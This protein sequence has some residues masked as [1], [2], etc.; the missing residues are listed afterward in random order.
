MFCLFLLQFVSEDR[1]EDKRSNEQVENSWRRRTWPD[2]LFPFAQLCPLGI[3]CPIIVRPHFVEVNCCKKSTNNGWPKIMSEEACTNGWSTIIS[4]EASFGRW[5]QVVKGEIPN[6]VAHFGGVVWAHHYIER[7]VTFHLGLISSK[8]CRLA[9]D[10]LETRHKTPPETK[11]ARQ[12]MQLPWLPW[13]RSMPCQRK[14]PSWQWSWQCCACWK[15]LGN[16]KPRSGAKWG[17][18]KKCILVWTRFAVY[19]INSSSTGGDQFEVSK[20]RWCV[21]D[22]ASCWGRGL[23]HEWLCDLGKRGGGRTVV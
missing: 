20:R 22:C 10:G 18:Q 23:V 8:Q 14:M 7:P 2:S 21:D 1:V 9:S 15:G 19:G 11:R 16:G 5:F 3:F 6:E 13:E 17:I 12:T 4:E